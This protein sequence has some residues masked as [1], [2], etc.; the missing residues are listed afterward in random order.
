MLDHPLN[1]LLVNLL[2]FGADDVI[3]TE[4]EARSS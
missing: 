4:V 3:Y 2:D 1:K